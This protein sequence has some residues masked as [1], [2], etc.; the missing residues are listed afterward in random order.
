M[1]DV[2][3]ASIVFAFE[4]ELQMIE[5]CW[6]IILESMGDINI[7][8]HAFLQQIKK[9]ALYLLNLTLRVYAFDIML[10]DDNS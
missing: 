8:I 3:G 1:F 2:D 9:Y 6:L 5:K 7:I 4:N 10:F